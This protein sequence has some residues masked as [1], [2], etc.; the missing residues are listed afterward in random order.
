[1]SFPNTLCSI[2]GDAI[3][4]PLK[5]WLQVLT[6]ESCEISKTLGPRAFF[7]FGLYFIYT[8]LNETS[9]STSYPPFPSNHSSEPCWLASLDLINLE[10]RTKKHSNLSEL[11]DMLG[12]V[13]RKHTRQNSKENFIP[14]AMINSRYKY[15]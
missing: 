9:S 12:K 3:G 7:A 14:A 15:L 13:S 10:L 1:M 2:I 5:D 6:N 11:S 8:V 4:S